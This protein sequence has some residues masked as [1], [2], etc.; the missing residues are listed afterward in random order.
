MWLSCNVL[1]LHVFLNIWTVAYNILIHVNRFRYNKD[2]CLLYSDIHKEEFIIL[3]YCFV[4][5]LKVFL[6]LSCLSKI[7]AWIYN[8]Y[9]IVDPSLLLLGPR[10]LRCYVWCVC[11]LVWPLSHQS[12]GHWGTFISRILIHMYTQNFFFHLI[13]KAFLSDDDCC[14]YWCLKN[15]TQIDSFCENMIWPV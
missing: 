7:I 1:D 10:W 2:N 9:A 12:R 11:S 8:F 14:W 6:S 5:L 4:F 3:Y 15:T 13:P